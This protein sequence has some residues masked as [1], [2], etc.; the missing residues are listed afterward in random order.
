MNRK[1]QRGDGIVTHPAWLSHFETEMRSRRSI[2][3]N[4]NVWSTPNNR[5]ERGFEPPPPT[6]AS[7]SPAAKMTAPACSTTA[8]GTLCGL[9]GEGAVSADPA[10]VVNRRQSLT[11]ATLNRSMSPLMQ[12]CCSSELMFSTVMKDSSACSRAWL[13]S[14]AMRSGG[15]SS[16]RSFAGMTS[17]G[18]SRR[19]ASEVAKHR[20]YFPD[21]FPTREQKLTKLGRICRADHRAVRPC[22]I[23]IINWRQLSSRRFKNQ[24]G[25][26]DELNISVWSRW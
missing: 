13:R 9:P 17:L 8:I 26:F 21:V 11:V 14:H 19:S 3:L 5:C 25:D 6:T 10:C 7:N 15:S 22:G 12:P 23:M 16:V 24:F 1:S 2:A 20:Q 18:R 4:K